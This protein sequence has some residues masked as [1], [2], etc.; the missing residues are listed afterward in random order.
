MKLQQ[1]QTFANDTT[2]FEVH[3]I[4]FIST[5][6]DLKYLVFAQKPRLYATYTYCKSAHSLVTLFSRT[7]CNYSFYEFDGEIE[8]AKDRSNCLYSE[9]NGIRIDDFNNLLFQ[10]I[11]PKIDKKNIRYKITLPDQEGD[12]LSNINIEFEFN[13]KTF[14]LIQEWSSLT[15]GNTEPMTNRIDILEQRLF[16]YIHP[17]ILDTISFKFDEFKKGYDRQFAEEQAK[18]DSVFRDSIVNSVSNNAA[19]WAE[20]I[21]QDAQKDT[22]FFMPEWKFPLLSGDT[23]YSDSINSRFL[24]IDMWYIACGP[25][26]LAMHEL[27]YIDTSYDESLFKMLSINISDK[28]TAKISQVLK[29][30]NLKS[31]VALAYDNRYDIEMSKQMGNCYGYPQLYLIDMKTRQVIWHS[32][33]YYKGFT[34]DIEEIIKEKKE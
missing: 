3:E 33:G 29:N 16:K 21:P 15:F 31:D 7:D 13:R 24:L 12:L 27:A 2:I 8:N 9:A 25:C 26:R 18:I 10:R 30:L 6:K 14:N 17:D 4:F 11:A 34:K 19:T 32:C 22:L 23:I 5:P 28:D 20:E 1:L